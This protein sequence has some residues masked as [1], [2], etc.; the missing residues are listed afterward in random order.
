VTQT[1]AWLE[2]R[3]RELARRHAGAGVLLALGCAA[4]AL[5]AGVLLGRVGLYTRVPLAVIGGWAAAVAAVVVGVVWLRRRRGGTDVGVLAVEVE[6]TG[7]LRRGSIAGIAAYESRAGSAELAAMADRRAHGW[8]VKQGRI[9]LAGARRDASRALWLG[10]AVLLVGG[11][12]LGA[13]S[14][15]PGRGAAFW[16]PFEVLGSRTGAIRLTV[17]RADVRRGDTITVRI[18]ARG[19]PDATLW[20]RAPGEP[21]SS[22]VVALDTAGR[23]RM[24]LGPLDSDR[25]LLAT[26][27][28]KSSDTIQVRVAL[29]AF[30]AELQLLARYPSYLERP[31]E[32]LAPGPDTVI[33]PVG[34][35]IITRGIATVEIAE[36][37]WRLGDAAVALDADATGFAGALGVYRSGRWRLVVKPVGSDSLDEPAPELV[38]VAVP[39]STPVV[40]VPV[41]GADTTAPLSLTLPLV[42]DSRDDHGLTGVELVS[43][44]V[45]RLGERRPPTTEPIQLPEGVSE[46]LV[47]PWVLDLNGRG[48]LPGDTAFFKVRATDNAP[49]PNVGESRTYA[50]RL[51][52]MGELRRAMREATES[53]ASGADSL[54]AAQRELARQ[55]E[56]LAAERE[57]GDASERGDRGADRDAEQLPFNSV[58]RAR[59]LA[60]RQEEALARAQQMR[61][62]LRELQEA[63][64][65]A[66]LTDPE[67]QKQLQDLRELLEQALTQEIAEKLRELRDA[68]ERLD[69]SSVREALEQL[70]QAAEEMRE[71]L[72]RGRELFER[73]ALEGQMTTLADDADELAQR[74]EEWNRQAQQGVDSAMAGMEEM[75]AAQAESLAAQL[76]RLQEQLDTM[77]LADAMQAAQQRAGDASQ[78]MQQ[79]QQQAKRG[80]Q[81]GAQ[82]SGE[83]ASQSLQPLSKDLREQRDDMREAWRQEVLDAMDRALVEA[84]DLAQRQED[85]ANRL[86]RGEAGAELRGEQAAA[87]DGVDRVIQRVQD[88]AGKNALISPTLQTALGFAKL[89]MNES[90]DQLQRA[91]PNTRQAGELAGQAVDALN[92]VALALLRSR[93][94]VAGSQS[95]SGLQEAVEQMAQLAQQQGQINGQAGQLQPMIPMGGDQLMQQL[96]AMAEQQRALAQQLERLHAEGQVTGADALAEEARDLAGQLDAGRLDD[97]TVERQD[98]LYHR[99][100]DAGRSLR[101][102]EEDEKKDRVS[103]AADPGN[104]RPPVSGRPPVMEPRFRYPTWDE[105]RSLTPEERRLILDYFRRLNDGNR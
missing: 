31:D 8:L 33:V 59:E 105:L 103:E 94:D 41:P 51:P 42:I 1:R 34:T 49:E 102:D 99:L 10:A 25:F 43:W 70:A 84:A 12:L 21:W 22:S 76:G 104:V 75:L 4:A 62:E 2:R 44:R 69:A 45:T 93:S 18:A 56:D 3:R 86:S 64:W 47:L 16:R 27:G 61:D 36:A 68:L 9:S 91:V 78:H 81:Q 92:A 80:E 58:E 20:V 66:G 67:F 77:S 32:P 65:N 50:L 52:A 55:I 29:P 82:Q 11:G 6:R 60:D 88:A 95:G 53:I 90:L 14:L 26:T 19:W 54:V 57:R 37:A 74:Q 46:R 79:A 13:S 39:D 5:A 98:R 71:Q 89:R 63:A 73:A 96:R 101:K 40:T 38:L 97:Q 28:G 85:I 48:F 35:R 100:L 30:L 23:A 87:R 83:Q 17:D 7:G 24:R 72:E 15:R